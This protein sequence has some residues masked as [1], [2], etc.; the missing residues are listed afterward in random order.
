MQVAYQE[1]YPERSM[2]YLA[3]LYR[4]QM[5]AGEDYDEL[6]PCHGI[7]I[8]MAD[9]L[10]DESAWYNRYRMM[11]TETRSLLSGH[12]N[13][14]YLELGKFRKAL[15]GGGFMDGTGTVVRVSVGTPGSVGASG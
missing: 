12:W 15:G 13:L 3:G 1:Y 10:E 9:L 8:L 4:D 6:R 11:N 2:F 7:H 5:S 14:H